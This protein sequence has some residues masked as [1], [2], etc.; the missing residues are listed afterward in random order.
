MHLYQYGAANIYFILWVSNIINI[1][2]VAQIAAASVTGPHHPWVKHGGSA[3]HH[4]GS[5]SSSCLELRASL[6]DSPGWVQV[7]PF[8]WKPY[9][10]ITYLLGFLHGDGTSYLTVL[11]EFLPRQH[12][13]N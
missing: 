1:Y 4:A 7:T 10:P 5:E 6:A 2:F 8:H 12:F 13:Q 3:W 9:C 11:P